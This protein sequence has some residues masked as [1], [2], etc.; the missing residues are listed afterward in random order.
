MPRFV[1]NEK[2]EKSRVFF[3]FGEKREKARSCR[4]KKGGG[5]TGDLWYAGHRKES[6]M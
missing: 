5:E 2:N 3:F 6:S 1:Y 4:Y